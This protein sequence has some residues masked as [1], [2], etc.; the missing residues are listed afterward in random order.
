MKII[1]LDMDGVLNHHDFLFDVGKHADSGWSYMI[2][3]EAV[4]RL[5]RIVRATGAKVVLSSSWRYSFASAEG[6]ANLEGMLRDKGFS[7]T[8]IDRTPLSSELHDDVLYG[9]ITPKTEYTRR[10]F[11]VAAW[12]RKYQVDAFVILDDEG[13]WPSFP[14]EFVKTSWATGLLDEH[15]EKAIAILK[16]ETSCT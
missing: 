7:G 8:I 10:N 5:D 11:E 12:L 16:G 4:A 9:M 13:D 6:L 15:V 3:P 1:F 14:K 2:D